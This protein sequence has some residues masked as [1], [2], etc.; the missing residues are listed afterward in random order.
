MR[1]PIVGDVRGT[2]LIQG[3]EFVADQAT[4]RPFP[5]GLEVTR[6]IVEAVLEEGVMVVPGMSGMI[7]GVAGDHI[8]ISPPYI[9]TAA[10]VE[11][12]VAALEAA[13]PRVMR[14]LRSP[15]AA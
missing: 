15:G 9:F 11:R 1:F 3:V 7:D 14:D 6:R 2:G 4:R 10:D 8:Q 12:L 5:P 13:I